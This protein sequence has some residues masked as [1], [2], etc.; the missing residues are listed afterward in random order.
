MSITTEARGFPQWLVAD[1]L[2]AR[3]GENPVIESVRAL[4]DD[5]N[6][7]EFSQGL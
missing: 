6:Q 5:L 1:N 2:L 4:R 7:T 3:L